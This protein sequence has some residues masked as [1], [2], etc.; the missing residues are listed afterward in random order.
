M[1]TNGSKK[2]IVRRHSDMPNKH[3]E[4]PTDPLP[5]ILLTEPQKEVL[6]QFKNGLSFTQI[7]RKLKIAKSTLSSRIQPLIRKGLLFHTFGSYTITELGQKTLLGRGGI[8]SSVSAHKNIHKSEFTVEIKKYPLQWGGTGSNDYF[9]KHIKQRSDFDE[10]KNLCQVKKNPL[11][12]FSSSQWMYYFA[13]CTIRICYSTDK[14]TFF[15]GKV[16]GDSFEEIQ[17]KVWETF[18][19]YYDFMNTRGFALGNN[20]SS[21]NPHFADPNGFFAKLASHYTNKGFCI[22]TKEGP[23]YVDYSN[24]ILPEEETT[25]ENIA[26]RMENL[27]AS[28]IHSNSDFKDLDFAVADLEKLKNVVAG[29]VK[30]E[31]MRMQPSE[32]ISKDNV[33]PDYFG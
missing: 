10:Y 4:H 32:M 28:V 1:T 2:G 24:V 20:V 30:L 18:V 22:D 14:M 3:T 31:V 6:Q 27:A 9:N 13:E 21:A 7:Y 5:P 25:S 16:E 33:R 23:F 11:N 8:G 19:G 26:K 29:L 12:N 15:I 17:N